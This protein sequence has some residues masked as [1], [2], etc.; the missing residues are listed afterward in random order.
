MDIDTEK[1]NKKQYDWLKPYQWQKGETGNPGGAPKGK[2]LKTVAMEMLAKMTDDEKRE[3]LNHIDPEMVWKMAEGNPANN[4]D[5]TSKG[6]KLIIT[7]DESFKE[8]DGQIVLS[9]KQEKTD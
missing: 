2:R 5:I 6:E 3:F 4:T 7:F 9:E 8:R 1:Q